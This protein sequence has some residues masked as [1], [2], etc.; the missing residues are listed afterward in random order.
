MMTRNLFLFIKLCYIESKVFFIVFK[1]I[2]ADLVYHALSFI[3]TDRESNLT[4][5]IS[6]MHAPYPSTFL[7][8]IYL[9]TIHSQKSV[10]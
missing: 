6:I 2:K 9:T 8:N 7:L 5:E 1:I 4:G 10:W 3:K